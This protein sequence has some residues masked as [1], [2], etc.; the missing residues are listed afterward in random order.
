MIKTAIWLFAV[1]FAPISGAFAA[2]PTPLPVRLGASALL[3]F[4][5]AL[6]GLVLEK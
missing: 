3:D 4:K 6:P 5:E 2:E 1:L